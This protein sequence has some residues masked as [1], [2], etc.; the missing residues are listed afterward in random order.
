M[1]A[2]LHRHPFHMRAGKRCQMFADRRRAGE[3]HLGDHRM[4][5]EIFRDLGGNA[6]EQIDRAVGEAGIGKG[7][8]HRGAGGR[9]LLGGLEDDGAAGGKG[10][11]DLADR[12]RHRIVP[13]RERGDDAERLLHHH[14]LHPAP[15]GGDEAS[16]GA[17]AL[18]GEPADHV[19][20][21]AQFRAGLGQWLALFQGQ[22]RRDLL[23]ARLEIVGGGMQ[24][25]GAVAGRRL[26]PLAEGVLGGGK[27]AVHLGLPRLG[28]AADLAAGR[29]IEHR[30]CLA[31]DAVGPFA[32]DE[33]SGIGIHGRLVLMSKNQW[34]KHMR[35]RAS[36]PCS[37]QRKASLIASRAT[38]LPTWRSSSKRPV[39]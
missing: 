5:N 37:S 10:G 2:K 20:G 14:L 29:R 38:R 17:D 19:V 30:Q 34:S 27:R 35:V 4:R 22:D 3:G 31:A 15:P 33:K 12:L 39:R 23:D 25:P 6:V 18:F 36:T 11:R 16:I 8:D 9:R 24:Q 32:G 26:A 7:A 1:A 21:I 28:D 13:G